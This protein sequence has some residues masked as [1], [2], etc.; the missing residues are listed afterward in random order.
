[1]P[2]PAITQTLKSP[3]AVVRRSPFTFRGSVRLLVLLVPLLVLPLTVG[4]QPKAWLAQDLFSVSFPTESDGWVCGRWGT[5]LHTSDGGDSWTLQDS[6]TDYTLS[7]VLFLDSTR[8]WAV[9]DGGTVLLTKDGGQSWKKQQ[10]EGDYF[11]MGVYFSDA[12]TGWVVTEWTTILHTKDGGINW[13]IQHTGEDFI[14]K[15]ISFCDADTGWAVGEYGYIY[16][17]K[18]GGSTWTQQAGEFD[19]SED[20]SEI[21][22]GD[23]LFDVVAID[24]MTAWVVGIDGHVGRTT[25]G[26]ETWER[27]PGDFPKTQLFTIAFD[28]NGSFVIGGKA[29]MLA[30]TNGGSSFSMCRMDPE[31]TYGWIYGICRRGRKGFAAVGRK[32]WVYVSDPTG[33]NWHRID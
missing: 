4:S 19:F 13:E 32:G 23:F 2:L 5:L 24:P 15:S 7:D 21:I 30:S 28:G 8:G 20:G 12:Q 6:G 26:G 27:I 33:L 3:P 14:L 10:I 18:D 1:M 25:N 17:T 16:H 29:T 9:G 22:G 31:I 11:L